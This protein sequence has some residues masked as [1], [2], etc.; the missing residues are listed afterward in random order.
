MTDEQFIRFLGEACRM[1]VGIGP[2]LTDRWLVLPRRREEPDQNLQQNTNL[3]FQDVGKS[4]SSAWQSF[5]NSH[6]P[7]LPNIKAPKLPV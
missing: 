1:M 4:I 2:P 6:M 5:R 7:T 3:Q